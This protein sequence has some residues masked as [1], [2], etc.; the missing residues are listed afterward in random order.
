MIMNRLF[1]IVGAAAVACAMTTGTA[2][3]QYYEIAN[4]LSGLISPALSGSMNYRGF[5]EAKGVA[6]IGTNRANFLGVSTS[7]GFQ[8]RDWF[9]MGAG[10]GVDVAMSHDGTRYLDTPDGYHGD[11]SPNSTKTKCMIPIFT[12][13][14]F[15]IGG[16]NKTAFFI[17]LKLGAA[18]L[19][20]NTPL[21][22]DTALMDNDAQFY[23]VPTLGVRIPVDKNN[24]KHAFNIGVSYQLLTANNDYYY[25]DNITLNNVG[26]TLGYEW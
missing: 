13:F 11:Y 4:Q 19:I 12:D 14:R 1:K 6:G 15:K 7:Q 10:I 20:G 16:E 21:R 22:F 17:D 24:S 23:M 3:A 5:V 26:I 18:W 9:F 25:N 8:Y 2:H